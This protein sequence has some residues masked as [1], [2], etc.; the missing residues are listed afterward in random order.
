MVELELLKDF[1]FQIYVYT[2]HGLLWVT[3]FQVAEANANS[4]AS[5]SGEVPVI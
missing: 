4:V 2:T 1:H 5:G 3:S